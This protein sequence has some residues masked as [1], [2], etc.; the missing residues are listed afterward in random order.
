MSSIASSRAFFAHSYAFSAS[1][2]SR[3]THASRSAVVQPPRVTFGHLSERIA[4]RPL[5]SGVGPPPACHLRALVGEDR[6]PPCVLVF[7]VA[8]DLGIPRL[9]NPIDDW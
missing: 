2:A 7:A 9:L 5:A 3:S 4:A 6:G 1:A 8:G